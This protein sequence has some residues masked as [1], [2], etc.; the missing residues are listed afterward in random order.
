NG[1]FVT[2]EEVPAAYQNLFE[3]RLGVG[4]RAA[5]HAQD[6]GGGVL[7]LQR[8]AQLPREPRDLC[9]LANCPRTADNLLR[10]AVWRFTAFASCLAA[11]PHGLPVGSKQAIVSTQ[12]S[13]RK[14][15]PMSLCIQKR[16][17]VVHQRMSAMGQ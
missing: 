7:L 6:F 11:A 10:I 17:L 12:S 15:W 16:T 13:T 2:A 8:L 1:Q 5:D 3:Y 14:G 4:H 9:L